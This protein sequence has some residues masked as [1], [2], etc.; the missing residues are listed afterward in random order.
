MRGKLLQQRNGK[1]TVMI[2]QL[3]GDDATLQQGFRTIGT[4]LDNMMVKN[5]RLLASGSPTPSEVP[6]PPVEAQEPNGED[7]AP[8]SA[9]AVA[10]KRPLKERS[11]QIIE[12][13]LENRNSLPPLKE[14]MDQHRPDSVNKRYLLTAYW[15]KENLG[16]Q[17]VSMDHMHTCLRH[18]DWPTPPKPAQPLREMKGRRFGWFEKGG[19]KGLYKLTHVGDNKSR[20]IIKGKDE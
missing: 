19:G 9:D 3:E 8:F 13:S 12:L 5:T 17:E 18:M 2:F 14:F 15:L 1:M 16:I 6:T 4:A 11:P 10:P 7:E 20:E